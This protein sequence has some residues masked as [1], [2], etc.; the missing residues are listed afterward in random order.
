M[1]ALEGKFGE[2]TAMIGLCCSSWISMSRG[3]SHRSFLN[4]MGYTGYLAVSAANLMTARTLTML[5]FLC[6]K[7]RVKQHSALEDDT[8]VIGGGI[9][10]WNLAGRATFQLA[11]C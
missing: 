1:A 4:P 3:S 10:C 5:A 11:A 7:L 9:H 6:T 8:I 2:V